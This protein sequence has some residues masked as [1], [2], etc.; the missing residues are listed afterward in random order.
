MFY[1]IPGVSRH[2]SRPQR[3]PMIASSSRPLPIL[4][5][6]TLRFSFF[7]LGPLRQI[8][9]RTILKVSCCRLI[10]LLA[11]LDIQHCTSL[12]MDGRWSD[13]SMSG[14]SLSSS[15]LCHLSPLI[16]GSG[17][18]LE[19]QRLL[20]MRIF[21]DILRLLLSGKKYVFTAIVVGGDGL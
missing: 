4:M 10:E 9:R 15:K 11:S 2:C 20:S 5:F 13:E 1:K 8:F 12:R 14:K 18:V 6:T 19:V 3:V 7:F 16:A 17:F 21:H